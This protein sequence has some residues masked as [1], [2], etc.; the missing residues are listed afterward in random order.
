MGIQVKGISSRQGLDS[1]G[2]TPWQMLPISE[3]RQLFI[4]GTQGL[5][6]RIRDPKKVK[7]T[8]INPIT[9]LEGLSE[10]I[11]YIDWVS[12]P[13]A[14]VKPGF[15]LE[16][17]VK[18]QKKVDV[19][20]FYIDD[21]RSQITKRDPK[22]IR[23]LV[24]QA[25]GILETQTNVRLNI[26]KALPLKVSQ[27]F[28]TVVRKSS[29]FKNVPASEDEWGDLI[30]YRDRNADLTVFFVVNFEADM[31]PYIDNANAATS[32]GLKMCVFEDDESLGVSARTLAH[33]VVHLLASYQL[34]HTT[35]GLMSSSSSH[36]EQYFLT[37]NEINIINPSGLK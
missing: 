27:D 17:C 28:G 9:V 19:S 34:S 21:G 15:S 33:E 3:K 13:N 10:G 37:K 24:G 26:K 14:D 36:I 5:I 32:S 20:F 11:T 22:N 25:N 2:E 23:A 35:T 4:S 6:P 12:S 7:L 29:Q 1:R 16:V 31:T 18:K 30:Q 8:F